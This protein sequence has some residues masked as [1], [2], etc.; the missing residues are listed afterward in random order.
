MGEVFG[1]MD[2]IQYNGGILSVRWRDIISSM[3]GYYEHYG[4]IL[5][6]I[7]GYSVLSRGIISTLEGYHQ[8]SGENS[9]QSDILHQMY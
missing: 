9:V 1:T 2:G 7:K 8:Y 4:G 3:K 6:V 5:S